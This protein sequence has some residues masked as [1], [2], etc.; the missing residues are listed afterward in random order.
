MREV[1]D[2][3]Y[4]FLDIEKISN[5]GTMESKYNHNCRKVDV[6]NA[7]PE[8][9]HLNE[10][11][12][13]LPVVDGK[14]LTYAEAFR[15]R[16][17]QNPY[18]QTH[19]YRKDAVKGYEVLLTY[20][21]DEDVDVEAWKEKSVQWL[22]D[23]FNVAGDG[24]DN[25]LHAVFHGDE[26]GNAHIH[27]FVVPIDERSHLCAKS[28]TD[29][30]KTMSD[31][32]TSYADAVEDL[33]IKRGV[34]GSS[35]QHQDIRRMYATLNNAMNIPE[36]LPNET[37]TEYRDRI[38]DDV[39]TLQ[40]ASKKAIDDY[41]VETRRDLDI[42]RNEQQEELELEWK[43]TRNNI[44]RDI[45]NLQTQKEALTKDCADMSDEMEEYRQMMEELAMQMFEVKSRIQ[46]EE[47]RRKAVEYKRKVEQGIDIITE[48]DPELGEAIQSGIQMAIDTA[49]E[50]ERKDQE[51]EKQHSKNEEF[52]ME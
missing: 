40:A 36:P 25:V 30:S 5:L 23:T 9:E 45:K 29:G 4:A 48:S 41:A 13:P 15:E 46:E 24:H 31:L 37:A 35:A 3:S 2:M 17:E 33:G 6:S 10:D 18:Y 7:D 47:E 14:E 39:K 43:A 49:N 22:K 51:H 1:I 19:S 52:S 11:L 50:W 27:A 32:Q 28:F 26:T 16:I 21:K 34:E 44:N 38:L 42:E 12:I 20:S 8:K